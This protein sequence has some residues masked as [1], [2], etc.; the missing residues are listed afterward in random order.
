MEPIKNSKLSDILI[1]YDAL[2]NI[3]SEYNVI[4]DADK[5]TKKY[6]ELGI[7]LSINIIVSIIA[8]ASA[9]GSM[10][11]IWIII[12]FIS[13]LALL[14]YD[15]I[16]IV[17]GVD[18]YNKNKGKEIKKLEDMILEEV[19]DKINYTGI[20]RI[21]YKDRGQFLYLVGNDYF[22]P[23]CTLNENK[24]VDHQKD[25]IIHSLK[26][27][28]NVNEQDI[29]DISPI[30]DKVHYSIKPVHGSIQMNAFVFYDIT[31]K[32]QTKAKFTQQND[33]RKWVSLDK[34]K[35]STS[36]MSTNK[37]VIDLLDSFTGLKDS[38]VN[39][40]GEIKIIWNIT[41]KCPYN[42]SIC[43]THD[44]IREELS[45]SDKLKVLNNIS[46]AKQLIKNLDFAGGDPLHDDDSI[47]IIRTAINNLGSDKVSI[48]TTGKGISVSKSVSENLSLIKH[49][50]VTIDAAHYNLSDSGNPS[51]GLTRNEDEYSDN[52]IENITLVSDWAEMITINVP[53][54]NDDLSED[55]INNLVDKIKRIKEHTTIDIDVSILR[56]MPVGKAAKSISID[57]Y[58][59]Y[60]PLHVIKSIK[61]KL[62]S[63]NIPCKLHCSLRVL[64]D[65]LENNDKHHCSM[66]ENKLG[67]DC[68]GNVFACAWSAYAD[69][70]IP[71]SKHPF[72]LGN[73]TQVPL[74]KILN[75]ESRT[76]AYKKIFNEIENNN[77]R[78]Y[79]SLIS[80][81]MKEKLFENFDPLSKGD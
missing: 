37:D 36:A 41:K 72:Y 69:N 5:A 46:T 27:K 54:I 63:I 51:I 42:C 59:D 15:I 14:V 7:S 39:I 3:V 17:R 16:C 31:M 79:C 45:A 66:L 47:N 65:F 12:S 21:A 74:I 52:N 49:C 20:L 68:A 55:E 75:G 4:N 62:N 44:D 32:V 2:K 1:G 29:I 23:H 53:I 33:K 35:K 24:S 6:K 61:E 81:Y 77:Q 11:L 71:L 10:S 30:D 57:E 34:M 18:S 48:T 56:L 73:L 22:L 19:K 40:L 13:I 78:N 9:V 25:E 26:S 60:N 80:Y 67:V 38:F 28:S 50:E 76:N 43:A 70:K 64:P 58:K 8:I